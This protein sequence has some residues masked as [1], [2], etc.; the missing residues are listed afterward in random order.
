MKPSYRFVNWR[1]SIN[2][3]WCFWK[4]VRQLTG[5][6]NKTN[7]A[8]LRFKNQLSSSASAL[9]I[10]SIS[11]SRFLFTKKQNPILISIKICSLTFESH[12]NGSR[13]V[14]KYLFFCLFLCF[15]TYHTYVCAWW[16]CVF[17]FIHQFDWCNFNSIR[18]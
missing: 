12:A 16:W 4:G 5:C 9:S 13:Y 6:S 18:I 7:G 17:I 14:S 11:I 8:F 10:I 2:L 3:K 15:C 1:M